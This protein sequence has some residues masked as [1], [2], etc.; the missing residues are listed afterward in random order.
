MKKE[1]QTLISNTGL[2]LTME[3][4]TVGVSAVF[5]SHWYRRWK[6][7]WLAPEL[8]FQSVSWQ[9]WGFH[10]AWC[11]IKSMTKIR[12]KGLYYWLSRS[13]EAAL[14]LFLW[15]GWVKVDSP[16]GVQSHSLKM[17]QRQQVNI[18]TQTRNKSSFNTTLI[19]QLCKGHLS[20]LL[21]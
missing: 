20:F 15:Q 4:I 13:N 3:A 6:W 11:N 5:S 19:T 16:E 9:H 21:K 17:L 2:L 14:P 1:G 8:W 7:T 18:F 10:V 12:A